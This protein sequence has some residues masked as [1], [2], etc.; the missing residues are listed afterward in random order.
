MRLPR[1]LLSG[2]LRF[3]VRPVLGPPVPVPVQRA[4]MELLSKGVRLPATTTVERTVLGGRPAEKV[5]PPAADA[6]RAVLL[7]H[8]GAFITGSPGTHRSF[9]AHLAAAAGCA[10][11]VLDY[12]LAPENAYPAAVD[13]AVAAYDE[14]AAGARTSVVGDSAGGALALLLA[15]TR[16]PASL[17]LVSPVVDLT[18]KTRRARTGRDMIRE[19]WVRAGAAAF[20]GEA[21]ARGLSPLHDDLSA[22][23]PTLLHV[24]ELELL[25]PEGELFAQRA[26]AA[27]A[28]LELVL[29]EGLW[30]DVHLQAGLLAEA[31]DAAAAMGRWLRSR[32]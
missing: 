3:G 31:A 27:G 7:L 17:G 11:H 24:S 6:S 20:V 28:D 1:A 21:D 10:V 32:G 26:K 2:A 13:D 4:W 8:G 9:A 15:R 25:R 19:D 18:G 16:A 14:L 23:P 5:S 30:H 29:L 12:R 22:L